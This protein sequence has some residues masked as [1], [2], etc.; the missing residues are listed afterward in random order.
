MFVYVSMYY[1]C[2]CVYINIKSHFLSQSFVSGHLS[3]FYVL[4]IVNSAAMTTAVDIS[5]EIGVFVFSGYKPRGGIAGS[6]GSFIFSFLRTLHTVFHSGGSNL[7]PTSE[8]Q[9]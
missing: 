8:V 3:C 7:H 5:F 6:Y 9:E 2:V 4:V 1:I